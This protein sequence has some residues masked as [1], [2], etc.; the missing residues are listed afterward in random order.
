M[1]A[2]NRS[3]GTAAAGG[4]SRGVR[5]SDDRNVTT[6]PSLSLQQRAPRR[7]NDG[8]AEH[9]PQR[10]HVG[11]L[12]RHE[13]RAVVLLGAKREGG[14]RADEATNT[15]SSA[16]NRDGKASQQGVCGCVLRPSR[17]TASHASRLTVTQADANRNKGG[18][19]HYPRCRVATAAAGVRAG[20]PC[21]ETTVRSR[22]LMPG[23][24]AWSAMVCSAHTAP[25]LAPCDVLASRIRPCK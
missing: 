6:T 7:T 19:A 22:D 24:G 3:A 12:V 23:Q 9:L 20:S 15:A 2:A 5:E 14:G 25:L 21:N 1:C 8:P 4:A 16:G 18:N 11:A 17:Y 10:P 13:H